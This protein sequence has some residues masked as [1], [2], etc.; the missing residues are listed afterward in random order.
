MVVC[1]ICNREFKNN[2]ALGCHITRLHHILKKDY[3]NKYIL[4]DETEGHCKND[5]CTNET[6]FLS[7]TRGYLCFCSIECCNKSPKLKE[8]R[9]STCIERYGGNAPYCS[10]MVKAKGINTCIE[11]YG[12][13]S[14]IKNETI[15]NK[16]KHTMLERYGVDNA[17][18]SETIQEKKVQTSISRYG[19]DS[20]NR[21]DIVKNKKK[22]TCLKHFG[23][24][25]SLKAKVIRDRIKKT[26]V[27]KYGFEY[28][29]KSPMVRERM[30]NTCL[31]RYGTTC[32]VHNPI[33]KQKVEQTCLSR[34]GSKYYLSSDENRN[35]V[36]KNFAKKLFT[37][38]RL[39][40][41]VLPNFRIEEY[42]GA[43]IKYSWTCVKCNTV[44][45]D[46]L[47]NGKIP[48]CPICFPPLIGT[49]KSEQEILEYIKS[50]NIEV[51]NRNR[52]V[53]NGRELDIYIPSHNLAIEF[54]GLFWHSELQ[55][56]DKNYHLNKTLQCQEKEI[57]LIHIFE[58][59]WIEKPETIKSIIKAKLNL[60]TNKIPA[61]KCQ[62]KEVDN[63]QAFQFL[64]NNHLQG[65]I[66][67]KHLG[68]YYNNELVSILTYGKPR[69]NFKYEIEILRFCNKLDTIVIGSLSKLTKYTNSKS[70]LTYVDLRYGNGNSYEKIGFKKINQSEPGYFYTKDYQN[71][72]SRMKYQK[73]K[74]KDKLQIFDP[75]LTE[76]QNMQLNNYDRI[77]DCGNFVFVR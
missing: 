26:C 64:D 65:Y 4:V 72:E 33:I 41:L 29:S 20:P 24:D 35:R 9:K 42:K 70:I 48:R 55:G 66:N 27:E 5:G 28:V 75:N 58:D 37:E 8:V 30:R 2:N 51:E 69:F 1:Q 40:G 10:E 16:I 63:N 43:D 45:E 14:P 44:F 67:G 50:L 22:I 56:K 31:N 3:Y 34:Y 60:I 61:R 25:N 57:Q 77:W 49:S 18:K 36:S 47:D 62:L 12:Y 39:K 74:L 15:Y 52:S 21:S 19:V 46:D 59:E 13:E 7:L 17:S 68:L 38:D 76:W 54:N 32:S 23:V 71:R 53:L 6:R 73:H 11:K